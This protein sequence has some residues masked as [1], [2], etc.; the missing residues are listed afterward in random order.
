[1]RLENLFGSRL[2]SLSP[3]LTFE[4]PLAKRHIGGGGSGIS[5]LMMAAPIMS[6]FSLDSSSLDETSVTYS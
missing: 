4:L 6:S 2:S 3:P 5:W 1:M